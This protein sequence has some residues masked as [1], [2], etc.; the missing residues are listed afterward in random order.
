MYISFN[1]FSSK[2][3]DQ[4]FTKKI[5]TMC[6]AIA[7]SGVSFDKFWLC[8]GMPVL[9]ERNYTNPDDLIEG[10]ANK[11]ADLLG[12]SHLVC[13]EGPW[14][15]MQGGGAADQYS[16]QAKKPSKWDRFKGWFGGGQQTAPV[17][18]ARTPNPNDPMAFMGQLE[19]GAQIPGNTNPAF[20]DLSGEQA[21]QD[22]QGRLQQLTGYVSS[23][24]QKSL[25]NFLSNLEKT[26]MDEKNPH[27][28]WIANF[29]TKSGFIQKMQEPLM[30][31]LKPIIIRAPKDNSYKNKFNQAREKYNVGQRREAEAGAE[32]LAAYAYP[33]P[34]SVPS[35][36]NTTAGGAV[37]KP[38]SQPVKP[39]RARKSPTKP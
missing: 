12:V 13:E 38:N 2:R 33:S 3:S 8:V 34:N 28:Q 26:G 6:E 24:F 20:T 5:N 15:Q 35:Q 25:Q 23:N 19:K 29:L 9:M 11:F 18:P 39:K 7:L 36:Q 16:Q 17:A 27:I 32:P 10:W 30:Q 31:A 22:R 4:D 1:E 14:D 21:N 37:G